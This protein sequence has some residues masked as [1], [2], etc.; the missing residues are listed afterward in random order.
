[1]NELFPGENVHLREARGKKTEWATYDEI[2]WKA[3][4]V[5]EPCNNGWMSEIEGKQ[6]KPVLTPLISGATIPTEITQKVASTL[7]AWIYKT[8]IVLDHAHH[9]TQPWFPEYVRDAFRKERKIP[10]SVS[11]WICGLMDGRRSANILTQYSRSHLSPTYHVHSYICTGNIGNFAFQFISIKQKGNV[12][13][14]PD[15]EFDKLVVPIWPAV[16]L[17]RW[18]FPANLT[19]ESQF[20][21]FSDRWRTISHTRPP[22]D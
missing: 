7:A 4:V 3:K 18:P 20:L 19:D 8:V 14:F 5:C 13:I 16:Y 21:R 10:S 1:M 6:A 22:N 17:I 11:M 9:R 15:P 2:D 12:E